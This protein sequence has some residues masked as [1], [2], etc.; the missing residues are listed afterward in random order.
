MENAEAE[1]SLYKELDQKNAHIDQLIRQ[2]DKLIDEN[3]EMRKQI[4]LLLEKL[5]GKL[6]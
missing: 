6:D 3:T 2:Q 1:Y 4:G 5:I